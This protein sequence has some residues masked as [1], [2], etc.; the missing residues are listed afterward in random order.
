MLYLRLWNQLANETEIHVYN[1]AFTSSVD[2]K[3]FYDNFIQE[4]EH[5]I[6]TLQLVRIILP[7]AKFLFVKSIFLFYNS[8]NIVED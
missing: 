3:E 5:R 4:F 1:E 7:C 2:L 8:N 6:N